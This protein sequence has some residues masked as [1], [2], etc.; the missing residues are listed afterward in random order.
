MFGCF[1][2]VYILII[3]GVFVYPKVLIAAVVIY[4][5]AV[6]IMRDNSKNDIDDPISV[7]TILSYIDLVKN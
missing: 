1:L 6:V 2:F 7:Q 5:F 4:C 3:V